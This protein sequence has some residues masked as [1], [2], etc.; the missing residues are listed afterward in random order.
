MASLT[1]PA[2]AVNSNGKGNLTAGSSSRLPPEGDP[3]A[4]VLSAPFDPSDVKFKPAAV[5]GNRALALAYVDA[6]VIQDRLDAVCGVAGWQD[7]YRLLPDGA[8]VCRLRLKIGEEWITKVDVGSPSGQPDNGDRTKAAFSDALKRAAVKFG[9]GRYLYRLPRQWCDYDPHKREFF[10]LPA[11]PAWAVPAPSCIG[12]AGARRLQELAIQKG[13]SLAD[14]VGRVVGNG[15]V[16]AETLTADQ[17]RAMWKV[18]DAL[19]DA[20][21][22]SEASQ[23]PQPMPITKPEPVRSGTPPHRRRGRPAEHRAD[24]S[25]A[26]RPHEESQPVAAAQCPAEIEP[27]N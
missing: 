20:N 3:V 26:R 18:L 11:L 2:P 4:R 15:G 25:D 10:R 5:S 14:Y 16:P 6:R 19:P 12:L 9:V 22:P 8:V 17:A 24:D 21:H 27:R 1:I 13:V 7:S 23:A